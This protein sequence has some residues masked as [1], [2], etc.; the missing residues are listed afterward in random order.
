MI[1]NQTYASHSRDWEVKKGYRKWGENSFYEFISQILVFEKYFFSHKK[2]RRI[3]NVKNHQLQIGKNIAHKA[4]SA[5]YLHLI[6][7]GI[8]LRSG[9]LYLPNVWRTTWPKLGK[10]Y[11][12][13]FLHFF[14]F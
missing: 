4:F 11:K 3:P 10:L 6:H 2:R 12:I 14:H 13:I 7:S 5:D 9:A 8:V 1:A